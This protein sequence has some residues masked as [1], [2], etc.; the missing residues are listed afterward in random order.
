SALHHEL[1]VEIGSTLAV[2]VHLFPENR[3]RDGA[4]PVADTRLYPDLYGRG[5]KKSL[6]Q[7]IKR[8]IDIAAS[9]ALLL[10]LSPLL[11]AIALAIK[12]TS[13]GPVIFRQERFGQFGARFKFLKFRTMSQ[14]YYLKLP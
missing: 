8:V 12:L 11:A 9:G 14:T 7:S 10:I 2:T 3:D 5:S 13:N 1:S 6:P 4:E